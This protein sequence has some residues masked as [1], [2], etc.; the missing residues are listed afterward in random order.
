M[1]EFE[2][3]FFHK[4]PHITSMYKSEMN[5]LERTIVSL[6]S[7]CVN[8]YSP[9]FSLYFACQSPNKGLHLV[10]ATVQ[11]QKV[12]ALYSIQIM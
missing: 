12:V 10:Q 8:S 11:Y 3:A 4:A 1:F 2:S 6:K 9:Q 7:L 5:G